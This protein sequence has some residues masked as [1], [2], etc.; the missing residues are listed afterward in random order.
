MTDP[1]ITQRFRGNALLSLWA[2][3]VILVSSMIVPTAMARD[4]IAAARL[5]TAAAPG[6]IAR[7][8]VAARVPTGIPREAPGRFT[9]TTSQANFSLYYPT[10]L[11]NG[12]LAV[13][14][15]P[16]GTSPT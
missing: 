3:G 8:T 15:S 7:T 14:I 10:Y 1:R 11:A 13:A 16:L 12:Y 2:C 9:L 4:P 5:S 6:T